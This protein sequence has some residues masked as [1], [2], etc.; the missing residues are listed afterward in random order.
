[1]ED[2]MQSL[3]FPILRKNTDFVTNYVSWKGRK[4][5]PASFASTKSSI[6]SSRA[7]FLAFE[8]VTEVTSFLKVSIELVELV[9]LE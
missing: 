5:L 3:S 4:L 9:D 1:M 2:I 8:Q 7:T 6:R